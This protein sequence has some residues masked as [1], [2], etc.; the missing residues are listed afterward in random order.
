MNQT[1]SGR[2]VRQGN[3]IVLLPARGGGMQEEMA[4]PISPA[5]AIHPAIDV[6]AQYALVRM[7]KADSALRE[8]ARGMLD[9]V[10]DQR[11]GIYK[12]DQLVP[13]Q[14]AKALGGWWKVIPTGQNAAVF[15]DPDQPFAHMPLIVFRDAVKSAPALLDPALRAAWATFQAL[16]RCQLPASTAQADI[17]PGVTLANLVPRLLCQA[18]TPPVN[19]V[20]PLFL[21]VKHF[22][23]PRSI[24]AGAISTTVAEMEPAAMDPGFTDKAGLNTRLQA[25]LQQPPFIDLRDQI[26]AVLVD[27][28]GPRRFNP[29]FAGWREDTPMEGA[30]LAKITALYAFRQLEFELRTLAS[31]R[32]TASAAQVRDAIR[33]RWTRDGL[34]LAHQPQIDRLFLLT[35]NGTAPA[36]VAPCADVGALLDCAI[37]QSD[38]RAASVLMG[39]L[40]LPY[41]GSLMLRSGLFSIGGGGLWMSAAYGEKCG[42]PACCPVGRTVARCQGS[43]CGGGSGPLPRTPPPQLARHNVTARSVGAYLT[44][45]QQRR[46]G[47]TA[48]S[49]L[50]DGSLTS[51]C[52]FWD[53]TRPVNRATPIGKCGQDLP[54]RIQH[55]CTTVD[56]VVTLNGATRRVQFVAVL[57]TIGTERRPV[58]PDIFDTFMEQA[59]R[60][61]HANNP[62]PPPPPAPRPFA[63]RARR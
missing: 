48:T 26:A 44:L 38:N 33:T 9:A 27:M 24:P 57:L 35:G 8:A 51:T 59:E 45:L 41:I 60:L 52:T 47:D 40:G 6:H 61:V 63:A 23:V 17:T 32:P 37:R 10:K 43:C 22:H 49:T 1:S 54:A 50:I 13:A 31:A 56:R 18:A 19:R 11:L 30:S 46:L 16:G 3:R 21:T 4:G 20:P 12:E 5:S 25:V 28:T 62:P 55:D 58:N 2:W 34:P 15:L 7:S 36:T 39:R 42:T 29:E 14:R 53:R